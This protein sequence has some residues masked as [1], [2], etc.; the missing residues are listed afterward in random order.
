MV[1]PF[2]NTYKTSSIFIKPLYIG[3]FA[4]LFVTSSQAAKE[5]IIEKPLNNGY[6]TDTWVVNYQEN[7]FSEKIT[8]A[9]LL[10]VPKNFTEEA[11][12]LVR[13]KPFFTNFSMQY[14]ESQKNLMQNGEL[15]NDSDKFEKHGY[16]YD[17]KQ[18]LS[19]EVDGDTENYMLS[20][21][22]QK[23]HL[24]KLF[25]TQKPIQNGQLGMSWFYS[26]TFKEMPSFRPGST[27]D[28]AKDFFKQINH[29]LNYKNPIHFTLK[30]DQGHQR[31]FSLDTQRMV[32][33]V[34][35]EVMEFCLTNRQLK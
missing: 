9:T 12:F 21:G 25:K 14:V 5:E 28:D 27:P 16:I 24:T 1:K 31:S 18:R 17:E 32:D 35:P 33:F 19:V 4:S 10:Y 20:V 2:V 23:N 7:D 29:A 3:L 13:C 30:T 34:P 11:A 6:L 26:F 8:E 22:G 15:N